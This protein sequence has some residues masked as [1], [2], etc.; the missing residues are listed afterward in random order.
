MQVARKRAAE[1]E[2]SQADIVALDHA[3]L[4]KDRDSKDAELEHLALHDRL[5]DIPNRRAF[6]EELHRTLFDVTGTQDADGLTD[7][8]VCVGF[9]GFRAVNESMGQS[10]G[11]DVLR[12]AAKR[13]RSWG[14][15]DAF[16]A[17]VGGDE[18]A[19]I[20]RTTDGET[21]LRATETLVQTLGRAFQIGEGGVIVTAS[22]GLAAIDS[23]N[24]GPEEILRRAH[25][26]MIAAKKAGPSSIRV[27]E[28]PMLESLE[29]R[30][31]LQLDLGGAL[32]REEFELHFQ[33]Q[34]DPSRN[35]V[36]GFEALLRWRHPTKGYVPPD[37]F[38][39][40]AEETGAINA[41]GAWVL[42][43]ACQVAASWNG[44]YRIAVNLSPLQISQPDFFSTLNAAL[45]NSGLA[46]SRLEL[47]LTET[48]AF[49]CSEEKQGVLKAIR[50]LGVA[51]SIDDFGTGFSSMSYLQKLDFDKIKIDKS[52]VDGLDD[53]SNQRASMIVRS[54][55][56][57]GRRMGVTTT[58]EGVETA[59]QVRLLQYEGCNEIQGYYYAKPMPAEDIRAFLQRFEEAAAK[60]G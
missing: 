12:S 39:P 17:R 31:G 4:Q 15:E 55:I 16:V 60:L 44:D 2:R 14:S 37:E 30:R 8:V 57:L 11:D 24:G 40:L 38:V 41:I 28:P 46:P 21:A 53:E 6:L 45:Q 20:L 48:S 49:D 19:L 18:F 43:Q 35:A 23:G 33:P 42:R 36:A 59:S 9:D 10:A 5:T 52:F 34:I 13:F 27:F 22:C 7:M 47:E 32:L 1:N 3:R 29:R 58:A 56:A 26:A 51:L 25:A 54:V 50:N